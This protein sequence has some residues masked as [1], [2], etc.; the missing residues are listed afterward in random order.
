MKKFFKTIQNIYS[1]EELRNR[2]LYTLGFLAVFRLGSFIALP[3]IDPVLLKQYLGADSGGILGMINIFL[4]GAFNRASIF[5]L[6]IMPYISASIVI[7]LLTV[8]LPYFQRMQ[9]EGEAGRKKINQIT[10]V[11]TIIITLVQSSAYLATTIPQE[12]IYAEISTTFF[13][14]SSMIILTAG[15]IFCMWVGEKIT[16][17]GIGNGIS[18]LIMINI[19]SGLPV[20]LVQEVTTRGA[21]GLLLLVL[22]ILALFFIVMAV[23]LLTTAIRRVPIQYARQVV[24]SRRSF[25]GKTQ[26]S[27]LPIKVN[28]ANVMPIIFAQ[29]LMFLPSMVANTWA[30][31]SDIAR[32]IATSFA[33][34]TSW[35]Y[36]LTFAL[37]IVAFTFIYTAMTINPK[38]MADDMKRNN[39]FIPGVKPGEST[40]EYISTVIDRV[41]LPGALYLS[42]VAVLPAF[43]N[44]A[45]V[46]VN[47]SQFYG[48]TSL[49]IMVGVVLDTLQQIESYLLMRHYESMMKSGKVKGRSNIAVAG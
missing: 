47:F 18:M 24:G 41:T 3:G 7:Q 35:Q 9:K 5:A 13:T 46:S 21:G 32:Y 4:G 14:F 23:V 1:I 8:S 17:K 43:A 27:Y 29:S 31:E 39:A 38:Q 44:M 22:E 11:L 33:D 45:G 42:I 36:N 15:T 10:R 12:A 40:T 34:F 26:R 48:G 25:T 30:D 16:E 28:A 37:L 19:I 49:I 2:I 6:G 20:A